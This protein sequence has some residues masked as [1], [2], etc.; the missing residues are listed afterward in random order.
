MEQRKGIHG[1]AQNHSNINYSEDLDPIDF[2]N[3]KGM[4]YEED[5]G[6]KFQDP[7]TGAHF[8]YEDMCCRL[9]DLQREVHEFQYDGGNYEDGYE[10]TAVENEGFTKAKDKFSLKRLQKLLN[11]KVKKKTRNI[12]Q[13]G[14]DTIGAAY[15][16]LNPNDCKDYTCIYKDQTFCQPTDNN[17]NNSVNKLKQEPNIYIND[18]RKNK[19]SKKNTFLELY[20]F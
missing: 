13:R 18:Q 4:F 19:L 7:E 20:L 14:C 15:N 17:R 9:M 10:I 3:Y 2:K 1:Q 5:S 11:S 6:Q 16:E 12:I 8:E